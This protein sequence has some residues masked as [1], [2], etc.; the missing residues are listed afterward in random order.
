[1]KINLLDCTLRD[2]GYYNTWDFPQELIENYLKAMEAISADYVEIGF[3]TLDT[4]DYKGGCGYSTDS[5]IR[6]LNIPPGV[7][8]AVMVNAGE[9]MKHPGGVTSAL[10]KLFAPAADSPVSLV[11]IAC[12]MPE[13]EPIMPGVSWLKEKG[14]LATINFMQIADRSEDEI[15]KIAKLVSNY[16]LDVLYF[17]D[18]MGGLNP[19]QTAGIIQTLRN[20]WKGEIGIHTHDN[21]CRGITNS[22]RAIEEGVT[23]VDGTVTGMGRG[24]GNAKTEYLAIEMEQYRQVPS[25]PLKLLAVINKYFKPMQDK[26]RWGS[27]PFYYLA[28]KYGIHPTYIQEMLGD[29]RYNEEDILAVI[30]HLKTGGGKKYRLDTMEAARHFYNGEPMG[31]WVPANMIAGKDVLVL[32]TG[33]GVVSHQRAIE[34]LVKSRKPFVIALNTQRSIASDLIDIR[35]ACHPMRLMADCHEHANL[36]QPLATPVSQLSESVLKALGNKQLLDFGLQ[37]QAETFAFY[38][39]HCILPT[40]LVIAYA[41]AIATSGK[42]KRIL[43]AG[44]DGYG[45]DDPRT[46]EMDDLFMGYKKAEEALDI[47]AITP[48]KYKIP[49]T[50]VYAM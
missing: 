8:L 35:V 42:A 29:T 19:D 49:T 33:P 44:F 41:L 4:N 3:R 13:I 27:N 21:M 28:G 14:Y 7:K 26:Y 16:P 5:Y 10:E 9:F 47:L 15:D 50:S 46:I 1:M 24:P 38:E 2:G 34:G 17:A 20:H 45:S 11:R 31:T 40:V 37:V 18:S 22:L 36:P 43:L 39:N 30:D 23:W 12:H 48:T 6:S 25:N 32:G